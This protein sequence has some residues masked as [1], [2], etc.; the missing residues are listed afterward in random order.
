MRRWRELTVIAVCLA[1]IG[2]RREP[3]A[4]I[5]PI[6]VEAT[7]R[8]DAATALEAPGAV[9]DLS[10]V[11]VPRAF[12]IARGGTLG[13][14]L[15]GLGLDPEEVHDAI[16]ALRRH[17]DLRRLRPGEGGLAYFDEDRRLTSLE[18]RLAGRGWVEA[19]PGE[20]GWESRFRELRR[21]V[22]RASVRGTVDGQLVT[23]LTAAGGVPELAYAMSDVLQWDLDFNRDLQPGDRFAVVY[24]EE[25]VED[26]PAGIGRILAL[27]Y[28]NRGVRLE[29]YL[30]DDGG[31]FDG[32]GRPLRK[33]FLRSPLPFTRITSRFSQHRFHPVLKVHRPH[34]GV[35]YG[36]PTGT[37]VKVTANGVVTWVGRKGGGGKMVEVK[38]P[39]G[40]LTAYLHLSGYVDG[41]RSGQRVRQGDVIGYVGATGLA[42]APH[43]DYRVQK[44]G[45]WLDPLS[46]KSVPAEPIAPEALPIFLALRDG[47]RMELEGRQPP[48]AAS[49][50]RLAEAAVPA[51]RP[52][53]PLGP[54]PAS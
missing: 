27:A 22:R 8:F 25:W 17:A 32:E 4:D 12:R 13:G 18:L 23:S 42:T 21:E 54:S 28:D 29:A 2:G 53:G 52:F 44:D 31:Y 5:Q 15:E 45:R 38:H 7:P 20:N 47:Y 30:A 34:Y 41:L 11:A 10:R 51:S 40:Y 48:P 26:E 24:E 37:P 39:N 14:A 19:V 50:E 49:G 6:R 9:L 43:L 33:M 35:D 16:E 3:L 36:A 1:C 46:I